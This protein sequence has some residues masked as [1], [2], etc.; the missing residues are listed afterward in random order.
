MTNLAMARLQP[1][2]LA[3]GSDNKEAPA[4]SEHTVLD[5]P[6][7]QE[8]SAGENQP[9][10]VVIMSHGYTSNRFG[11]VASFFIILLRSMGSPIG[12]ECPSWATIS[13]QEEELATTI[14]T[15]DSPLQGGSFDRSGLGSKQRRT[16]D[17]GAD[18]WT[19]YVFSPRHW[20]QCAGPLTLVRLLKIL[21]GSDAG[22]LTLMVTLKTLR[23]STVTAMLMLESAAKLIWRAHPWVGSWR[24]FWRTGARH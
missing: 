14:F 15:A 19:S 23:A 6:T 18:F 20:R 11:E 17:S 1:T 12:I 10:P 3:T 9:V 24:R 8:V 22:T 16:S 4:R 5:R 13:E 21:T 7:P 2:S